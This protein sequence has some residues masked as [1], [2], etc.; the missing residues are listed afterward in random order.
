MNDLLL[1]Y[2]GDDFT[3]STDALECLSRAGVRTA[4]F[5]RPPTREMLARHSGLQA[6][7]VAGTTRSLSPSAMEK[8][9][10]HAFTA[11]Q[12]LQP[13]HIH[14]KVCSTFDSAP[15]IGS[16][17]CAIDVGRRVLGSPNVSLVVG[18]PSLGRYCAFGHL[19]AT[20]GVNYGEEVF[21]LDRHPSAS[22]HSKTPMT[23]SDLRIHLGKQT[24]AKLALFDLLKFSLT[25]EQQRQELNQL[26]AAGAEVVLFDVVND[27]QLK[28]IGALLDQ[29]EGPESLRFAVGSS[30]V[31]MALCSQWASMGKLKPRDNWEN[32]GKTSQVLIVSGSCSPVTKSQI[33]WAAKN[34]IVE[35]AIDT[36]SVAADEG[37]HQSI[38]RSA[39]EVV[40]LLK[41]GKSVVAHT[42]KGNSDPRIAATAEVLSKWSTNGGPSASCSSQVLGTAMGRLVRQALD[43]T[44]V[45]RVC[46]AGG[47]TSSYLAQEIGIE[48][49]EMLCPFAPGSPICTA[50]APNSPADRIEINF[51]GGQVGSEE[52]FGS[53]LAGTIQ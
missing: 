14:Y 30:G 27:D 42:S 16:I 40:D 53:L 44:S 45:R 35:V 12:E 28:Q 7:G 10:V 47:D 6:V 24:K 43:E 34:G 29:S 4:L 48:T 25:A 36:A 13:R 51:K 33:E 26:V 9:L 20:A 8:E 39:N 17:G 41:S 21:R 15:E 50:H 52:F 11:L 46:V 1:T 3:G 32:P 38:Q 49:L 19:F 2:Y 22:G 23:E 18:A 5:T 31:E 37:S